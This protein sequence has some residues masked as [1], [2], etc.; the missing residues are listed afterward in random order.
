MQKTME[1][2]KGMAKQ[3]KERKYYVISFF[4]ADNVNISRLG[5]ECFNI[6]A[7]IEMSQSIKTMLHELVLKYLLDVIIIGVEKEAHLK[8]ISQ[9]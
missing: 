2:I 3:L 7:N 9:K 6:T 1:E 5:D 8:Q 4:S